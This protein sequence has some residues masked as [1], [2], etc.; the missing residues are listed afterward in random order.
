MNNDF[1]INFIKRRMA[2]MGYNEFDYTMTPQEYVIAASGNTSITDG[3]NDI[4]FLTNVYSAKAGAVDGSIVADDNAD[5]LNTIFLNKQYTFLQI[6]R[7]TIKI[8][9]N[10]ALGNLYVEFIRVSPINK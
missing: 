7:G 5:T 9:N 10:S 3:S 6:Y 2:E 8:T 4:H 1:I